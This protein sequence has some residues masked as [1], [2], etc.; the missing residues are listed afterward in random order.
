MQ[1]VHYTKQYTDKTLILVIITFECSLHINQKARLILK[2]VLLLR[3]IYKMTISRTADL[4]TKNYI[5]SSSTISTP[6][7][8]SLSSALPLLGKR[9]SYGYFLK[10]LLNMDFS[11]LSASGRREG[12][13][14]SLICFQPVLTMVVTTRSGIRKL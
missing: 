11:S 3:Y 12:S 1:K 7:I 9:M 4:S 2:T 10:K 14:W 5:V 6:S 13:M 8:W